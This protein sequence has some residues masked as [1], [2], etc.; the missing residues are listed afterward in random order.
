MYITYWNPPKTRQISFEEILAGVNNVESLRCG[1]DKTSTMTVSRSDLTPRLKMI[2]DVPKMIEQLAEFNRKYSELESNPLEPH[3]YHFSIPKKSGGWRPIDA[4]DKE[5]SDALVELQTLLRSFMIADYHTNAFA[6]VRGRSFIDAVRKHQAGHIKTEYDAET[7][8]KKQ[9]C[10]E[11]NW[12]VKL[13]FHG[14]F[15]STT[16]EFLKGMFSTIYPFALIM[17]D[18]RG[19]EELSKALALCFLHGGLPQGTPISPWLTN[20][21][22]IPFDHIIT[23]KVCSGYKMKD[24][25]E[26]EFTYTR[27]ADDLMFSAY[28]SFN[29]RE[30]EEL[31]VNVLNFLH[32]TFTLN[33]RKTHY[34]NRHNS[35]NWCLGL[36]WNKD[37]QITVGWR[38]L[39]NIRSA[40]VNYIKAKKSGKDWELEDVQSF[41]GRLKYY[42]YVEPEVIDDLVKRYNAKFGVDLWTMIHEDLSPKEGRAA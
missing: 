4:P 13:D 38:N 3:Y 30:I 10:Y 7:G 35:K 25:I 28:Q 24:G 34:G 36:M 1:G 19:H 26:R 39:K 15:P 8:E 33:E 14:F 22:M 42:W 9:I 17:R 23:R 5:L 31:V 6:Y 41:N 2:T 11:N 12:A 16:P 21:M 20:V 40:M 27:Y 37:N 29:P 18:E 32:A